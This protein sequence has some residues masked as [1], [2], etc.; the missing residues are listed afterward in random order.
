MNY[1]KTQQDFDGLKCNWFR[2]FDF[3]VS[4]AGENPWN[5]GLIFGSDDGR[6]RTTGADGRDG[7]PPSRVSDSG[8][9][10]NG[11][12]FTE[13][14]MAVSTR[15]DVTFIDLGPGRKGPGTSIAFRGGAHGVV[16]TSTGGFVAPLGPEGLLLMKPEPGPTQSM[17]ISTPKNESFN[18][19]KIARVHGD[20]HEDLFAC[21]ARRGGLLAI[22]IQREGPNPSRSFKAPH[23]DVVDVCALGSLRW[24]R[25]AVGLGADHSLHLC[26]DLMDGTPPKTLHLNAMPGTAYSI[27]HTDGHI[28]LLT[29]R[30]LYVLPRLASRFL[31]GDDIGGHTLGKFIP[32]RAVDAY[33]TYEK[34][35][36]VEADR[37][38]T[39]TIASI[40]AKGESMGGMDSSSLETSP[41]LDIPWEST[42]SQEWNLVP[43]HAI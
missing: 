29:S 20:G 35:L 15:S 1:Y 19:Y 3:E 36:I 8:E 39:A 24:P 33:L 5:G 22:T 43:A 21:A 34:L 4:W 18:L 17:R 31:D 27:L 11:V 10:I 16:A 30:G 12:A 40:I 42:P 9:A 6:L 2:F 26:R 32:C 25:A 37:V 14:S 41:I 23:L 7:P 38:V 28:F 13:E